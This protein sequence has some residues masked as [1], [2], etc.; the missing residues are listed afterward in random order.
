MK[1]C[2]ECGYRVKGELRECP[3]C[4]V[5]MLRDPDG[6]TVRIETHVHQN[7]NCLLPNTGEQETVQ[8]RERYRAVMERQLRNAGAGKQS[9]MPKQFKQLIGIAVVVLLYALLQACSV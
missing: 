5:R 2:P 4:G 3:L 6:N 8:A 1:R 7:E 9:P